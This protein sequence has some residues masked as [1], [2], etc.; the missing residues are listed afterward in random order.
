MLTSTAT[1]NPV[2]A[3]LI[4][5][6]M[7]NPM[8]FVGT[9]IAPLLPVGE[10]SAKYYVFDRENMA[11]TPKLLE[12]APGTRY[13]RTGMKLSDD[14]Y[15]CINRGIE[16]P[17][18]DE[19]R[20]KYATAFAADQ[21]AIRRA[22]NIIMVNHEIRVHA[23][24]TAGGIAGASPTVKW[25]DYADTLSNPVGD[26]DVAKTAIFTA[27]GME[28]TLF[29]IPRTV[30]NAL[31][32]HP[33]ILDKIKYSQRGVVTEEILSEIFGVRVVVAKSLDDSAADGQTISPEE[34]WGESCILCVANPV[35]DIQAPNFMR[36]FN[37]TVQSGRDGATVESYREDQIQSDV[38]R[39]KQHT[40]EKVV[41]AELV[42]HFSNT[43]E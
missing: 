21:A 41:G 6:F 9:R 36:T 37:W 30:F 28:P 4:N 25:N 1:A 38:H 11:R 13:P 31:K 3:A 7:Q 14:S 2:L 5:N 20:A 40:D 35:Q 17:V 16:I 19:E 22:R 10:Q 27:S 26:V 42:Y 39:V 15:A 29:T 33:A 12:R 23:A 32:E 24:A 18:D 8:G 34:I 43:L